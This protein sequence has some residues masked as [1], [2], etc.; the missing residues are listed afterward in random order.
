M[1][2]GF[3]PDRKRQ[4]RSILEI[5]VQ[6]RRARAM[7]S[8]KA[9]KNSLPSI[10]SLENTVCGVK[11]IEAEISDVAGPRAETNLCPIKSGKTREK[12]ETDAQ[13]DAWIDGDRGTK[14]ERRAL[15]ISALRGVSRAPT[16]PRGRAAPAADK[17]SIATGCK[18][19]VRS[20]GGLLLTS[21]DL[22]ERFCESPHKTRAGR[23]GR[24]ECHV[25]GE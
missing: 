5:S 23:G 3:E 8:C 1:I 6:I 13:T 12:R 17:D 18:C 2:A 16:F 11:V 24:G 9:A 25:G 20:W 10:S 22:A 19:G 21:A 15:F 4:T 14:R 7:T